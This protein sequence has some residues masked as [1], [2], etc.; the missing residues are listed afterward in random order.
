MKM[1]FVSNYPL[2]YH[3][4]ILNALADRIDLHV[5]FMSRGHALGKATDG[6]YIDQWGVQPRF[7]YEFHWSRALR[8]LRV[9]FRVQYSLGVSGKLRRLHPDVIFFSSWGP[10]M[11]EPVF[12]KSLA[13][14]RAVMWAESTPFSGLL[15]GRLSNLLRRMILARVDA[16]VTNGS[17][18][19]L[20][21]RNLGINPE[22]IVTSCLPS[23][24]GEVSEEEGPGNAQRSG[25]RFLFVGRLIPRKRPLELVRAFTQLLESEPDATLTV[26]GDGPLRRE[27]DAAA[28]AARDA[29]SVQGRLEGAHLASVYRSHDVLVVPSVREV[30]GL[31]VNEALAHGLHV[32]ATDQVASAHDLLDRQTGTL[33]PADD[34]EAMVGA[35]TE[36]AHLQHL[37]AQRRARKA[38][39]KACTAS[40]FAAD[41]LRA[42]EIALRA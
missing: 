28:G 9:D 31:V 22:I 20:Y 15:R 25:K 7:P 40:A 3:T 27:V 6:A 11:L 23:R 13:K 4:P 35:L 26:V 24:P 10:L 33:V 37:P 29:I 30:W 41:I 38:R 8:S 14:R 16:Y 18:A 36:A 32:V 19:T 5:I 12:W 39:V 2:P 21:L 42:A 17:Q 1:V 34:S